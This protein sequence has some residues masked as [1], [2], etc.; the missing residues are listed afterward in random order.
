MGDG[1]PAYQSYAS[2]QCTYTPTSHLSRYI[3]CQSQPV[4]QPQT[5]C[6]Y[7]NDYDHDKP[8]TLPTPATRVPPTQEPSSRGRPFRAFCTR[9]D[10]L[11]PC[12]PSYRPC[13]GTY[14]LIFINIESKHLH[15]QVTDS[16]IVERV[17]LGRSRARINR[18]T[19]RAVSPPKSSPYPRKEKVNVPRFTAVTAA[20]WSRSPSPRLSPCDLRPEEAP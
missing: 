8:P 6:C 4:Q 17:V 11:Y 14:R 15:D 5:R 10:G 13:V 7:D 1:V 20:S 9:S 19:A 16:W 12:V 18:S 2:A 3:Y